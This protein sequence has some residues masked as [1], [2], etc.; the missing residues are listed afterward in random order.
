[1]LISFPSIADLQNKFSVDCELFLFGASYSDPNDSVLDVLE[2]Q[3]RG[4]ENYKRKGYKN[5]K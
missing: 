3:D 1:M 4:Q 5:Y 2:W